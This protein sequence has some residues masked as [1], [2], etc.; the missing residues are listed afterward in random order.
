MAPLPPGTATVSLKAFNSFA[1]EKAG[2]FLTMQGLGKASQKPY[3]CL[4]TCLSTKDVHCEIA[5]RLD[6]DKFLNA[7]SRFVNLR[8]KPEKIIS[9]N[10]SECM[11]VKLKP[12][13]PPYILYYETHT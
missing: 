9:N 4:F 13:S 10:S 8:G 6:T 7:L 11:R 2:P 1:V 3:L 12:Q 5:Y